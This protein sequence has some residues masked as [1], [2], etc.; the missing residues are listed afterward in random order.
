VI[1][2]GE[3]VVLEGH[4]A[5]ADVRLEASAIGPARMGESFQVRMTIGGRIV[6]AVALGPGHAVVQEATR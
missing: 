3:R 1:R 4:S 2:S 6:K 5:V